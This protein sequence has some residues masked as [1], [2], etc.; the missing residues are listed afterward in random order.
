[1]TAVGSVVVGDD[2]TASQVLPT[3]NPAQAHRC[4]VQR[5]LSH[6]AWVMEK[7]KTL[8]Q[9]VSKLLAGCLYAS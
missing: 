9:K 7:E 1:M 4:S 2:G 6:D 5:S 8:R 3:N